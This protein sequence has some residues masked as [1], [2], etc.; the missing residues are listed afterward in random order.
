MT[1]WDERKY[2]LSQKVQSINDYYYK[3]GLSH[4]KRTG[5]LVKLR[6][7]QVDFRELPLEI[8]DHPGGVSGGESSDQL[9]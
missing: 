4:L 7:V 9:S 8:G 1:L 5:R 3:I 6:G 2:L